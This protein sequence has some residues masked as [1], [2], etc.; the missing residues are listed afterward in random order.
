MTK[1]LS[2][3]KILNHFSLP[4][5][6]ENKIEWTT[7]HLWNFNTYNGNVIID[8]LYILPPWLHVISSPYTVW[9]SWSAWGG[10]RVRR[11]AVGR[12]SDGST[13]CIPVRLLTNQSVG[14]EGAPSTG[15]RL[16]ALSQRILDSSQPLFSP[17]SQN[18]L[19]KKIWGA[20][21]LMICVCCTHRG[22]QQGFV[23]MV[24]G[25]PCHGVITVSC[26]GWWPYWPVNVTVTR[27]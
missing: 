26:S 15:S 6:T 23:D 14:R 7:R 22:K 27:W 13:S 18:L 9:L 2:V 10:V 24:S 20:V 19:E 16:K 1:Q 12:E 5:R 25:F 17:P 3:R 8:S 21:G 4:F 11:E